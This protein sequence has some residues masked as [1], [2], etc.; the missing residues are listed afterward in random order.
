MIFS[1]ALTNTNTHWGWW[2]VACGLLAASAGVHAAK[3]YQWV[4]PTTGSVQLA[5]SP[6]P[7][8]RSALE[9]PRVR[10]YEHG[11]VIDDTAYAAP[12]PASDSTISPAPTAPATARSESAP[13]A[14]A[15]PQN[16]ARTAA[17]AASPLNRSEEFKALLEAWDR[18]Q[19]A[20][21][22]PPSAASKLAQP[23]H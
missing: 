6:P 20:H 13:S 5:G 4:D 10:V 2:L 14:H 18:E 1:K 17:S 8:Y 16:G 3:M 9:G 19:A 15:D 22:R 21:A 23:P 11:E 12:A 7:W